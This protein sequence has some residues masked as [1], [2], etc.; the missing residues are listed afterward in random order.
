MV[1]FTL[2]FLGMALALWIGF[3]LLLVLFALGVMAVIWSHL[4]VY[5]LKKGILNPTPGVR[6]SNVIIESETTIT[7]IEGDFK[8]VEEGEE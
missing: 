3:W 1:W 5:L 6:S 8:R 2:L 4:R 7:T